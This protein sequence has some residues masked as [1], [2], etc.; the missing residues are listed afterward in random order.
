MST[1]NLRV[2]VTAQ[3]DFAHVDCT[4]KEHPVN[5]LTDTVR[6][7][8]PIVLRPQPSR[9]GEAD[10]WPTPRCLREALIR[11]VLPGLPLASIWEPAGMT[12]ALRGES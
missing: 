8:D 5:R 1:A 4:V 3:S 6:H 12:T 7:K 9:H 11:H 10:N 2:T